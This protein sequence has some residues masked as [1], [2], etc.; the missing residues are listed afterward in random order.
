[1]RSDCP[2]AWHSVP[3]GNNGTACSG[4]GAAVSALGTCQ[5]WPGY[6]GFACEFCAPEY[7]LGHGICQRI[8][9]S[10]SVVAAGAARVPGAVQLRQSG[11]AAV[12]PATSALNA[13]KPVGVNVGLVVGCVL[14]ALVMLLLL[15]ALPLIRRK[16]LRDKFKR[17][18]EH[19]ILSGDSQE[20]SVQA[21]AGWTQRKAD[22]LVSIHSPE[23]GTLGTCYHY[24]SHFS[25]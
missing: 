8:P 15:A 10:F 18:L 9:G 4:H 2:L 16:L 17:T 14:V 1:M 20:A 12:A 22:M 7:Q 3:S 13:M 19:R 25:S 21:H 11:A 23:V 5:C 6:Q 24:L